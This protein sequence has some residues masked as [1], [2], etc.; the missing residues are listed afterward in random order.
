MGVHKVSNT[1]VTSVPETNKTTLF[2]NSVN[3]LVIT[4]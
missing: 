1:G 2:N 4:H 3:V